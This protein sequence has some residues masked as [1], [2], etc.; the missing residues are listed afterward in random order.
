MISSEPVLAE[1]Y[2][3]SEHLNCT[4]G[5]LFQAGRLLMIVSVKT[6]LISCI[7]SCSWQG[8]TDVQ[9]LQFDLL[10]THPFGMCIY[11]GDCDWKVRNI[12]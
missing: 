12:D 1:Q 6:Y 2:V 9:I 4:I 11:T 10:Q 7:I 8:H 3:F 5:E